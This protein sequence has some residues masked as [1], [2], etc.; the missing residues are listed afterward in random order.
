MRKTAP[1]PESIAAME[2]RI[3]M[4]EAIGFECHH[5]LSHM[6]HPTTEYLHYDF[7]AIAEDKLIE[8]AIQQLVKNGKLMG[9]NELRRQYKD[10]LT[11]EHH[12]PY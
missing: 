4:L 11:P 2:R 1:T 5:E 3:A 8:Y 9:R 12:K 7:S 6:K 10:L